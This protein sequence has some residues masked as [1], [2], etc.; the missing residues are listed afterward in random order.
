M[1]PPGIN[2]LFMHAQEFSHARGRAH[3]IVQA[4]E[5]LDDV[6]AFRFL[7]EKTYLNGTEK[8]EKRNFR[9]NVNVYVYVVCPREGRKLKVDV[10][11]GHKS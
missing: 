8:I 3:G 7:T 6:H 10:V 9:Q 2:H 1:T 11:C 4:M 5:I